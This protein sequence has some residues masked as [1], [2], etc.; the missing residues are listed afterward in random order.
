MD[1]LF[2]ILVKSLFI[3]YA[4]ALSLNVSAENS[5]SRL[6][7]RVFE[8][9][10]PIFAT[11]NSLEAKG[12]VKSIYANIEQ[13]KAEIK[14]ISK[15]NFFAIKNFDELSFRDARLRKL[16]D[17]A[18]NSVLIVKGGQS[19]RITN[20]LIVSDGSLSIS[21]CTNCIIVSTGGVEIIH[22]YGNIVFAKYYITV[23]HDSPIKVDIKID[24]KKTLVSSLYFSGNLLQISHAKESVV[25]AAKLL[26]MSHTDGVL[27]INV[28][29]SNIS[30]RRDMEELFLPSLQVEESKFIEIIGGE[31]LFFPNARK[32]G[33][34]NSKKVSKYGDEFCFKDEKSFRF[35]IGE[36]PPECCSDKVKELSKWQ[37]KVKLDLGIVF[38]QNGE[39][40]LVKLEEEPFDHIK[41]ICAF[42]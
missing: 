7:K 23:S 6:V 16:N 28:S 26:K 20:S 40:A 14:K 9:V 21:Y 34:R 24:P 11:S 17:D 5:E 36:N 32:A 27:G 41:R 1:I 12:K 18:D 39:Y 3:T 13:V 2:K 30:W 38:E 19:T 15:K 35:K 25:S 37:S 22:G 10:S 42:E 31:S 4:F 8:N 29:D 33:F